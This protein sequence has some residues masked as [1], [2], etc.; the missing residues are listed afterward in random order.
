MRS[1][2]DPDFTIC[3]VD[4]WECLLELPQNFSYW[5]MD[6]TNVSSVVCNFGFLQTMGTAKGIMRSF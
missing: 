4:L 2:E 1:G 5:F 3:N 6:L